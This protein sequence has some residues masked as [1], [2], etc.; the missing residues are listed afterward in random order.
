MAISKDKLVKFED[1]HEELRLIEESID[2][3]ITPSGKVY[4]KYPEGYYLKSQSPNH[5]GYLYVDFKSKY[6]PSKKLTCRVNRLVAIAYIPNPDN[7]PVVGHKDNDKTNNDVSNLYWTTYREN[8]MKAFDDKLMS[9]KEGKENGNSRA[10]LVFDESWQQVGEYDSIAACSKALGVCARTVSSHC[11]TKK[12]TPSCG[13]YFKFK[14]EP[15]AKENSNS[16]PVVVYDADW[17]EIGI[18][19]SIAACSQALGLNPCTV[20]R[21]CNGRFK[22]AANGYHF[23]FQTKPENP[24][25]KYTLC[26]VIAYDEEWNEIGRYES[27]IL[28]SQ[29]LDVCR[30]TI[31]RHCKQHTVKSFCGY[32]FRYEADEEE[33]QKYRSQNGWQA[34]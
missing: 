14:V 31:I 10:I 22:T 33:V 7:L 12:K 19:A 6:N 9:K 1:I 30:S 34:S 3:Y 11:N 8:T 23:Q 13:Y 15:K 28:C 25:D 2:H 17:N 27:V 26:P 29:V 32:H 5:K 16:R 20:S 18:Y 21:H 24:H 4:R